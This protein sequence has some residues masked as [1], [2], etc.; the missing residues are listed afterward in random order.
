MTNTI[1]TMVKYWDRL[2]PEIDSRGWDIAETAR[3]LKVSFQAVAKVRDGG[4]FGSKNNLKAAK[5]F[6]LDAEWL[7]TGKGPRRAT[8]TISHGAAEPYS[9][10]LPNQNT[11]D[12]AEPSA[13]PIPL[14]ELL[15]RLSA[16]L[17]HVK[18]RSRKL[19][20]SVFA[21]WAQNPQRYEE[22]ASHLED[23]G[24]T[25]DI[26]QPDPWMAKAEMHNGAKVTP[27]TPNGMTLAI[28]LAE[29]QDPEHENHLYDMMFE[30][31]SE[32]KMELGLD[33]YPHVDE[34]VKP[35]AVRT[36]RRS[37]TTPRTQRKVPPPVSHG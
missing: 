10:Y 31:M 3:Q 22:L 16:E 14:R 29:I 13:P 7:A 21:D 2:K 37:T 4:S 33:R 11:G 35:M 12:K 6:G 18:P 25:P 15:R 30:V 34:R 24:V 1:A 17:M 36:E 27:I 20:A 26:S 9:P 32:Q 28:M 19:L 8:V 23:F 5:L